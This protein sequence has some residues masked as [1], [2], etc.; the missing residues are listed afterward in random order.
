MGRNFKAFKSHIPGRISVNAVA[1][2]VTNNNDI[3]APTQ[4][5][6]GPDAL[7]SSVKNLSIS[8]FKKMPKK[9]KNPKRLSS[10]APQIKKPNHFPVIR[11]P[12]GTEKA[13]KAMSESN[14]LVFVV[15]KRADKTNIKEAVNM[16]FKVR[17][18]KVNTSIMP[19][20]I[21]KAFIMLAP[22]FK[23]SDVAKKI[24]IF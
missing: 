8:S 4:N 6:S 22:E 11:Y 5:L 13:I 3:D 19:G 10:S 21:K 16:M 18:K 2:E 1:S 20:G 14:T 7:A 12:L 23:A 15:D 24:G 9:E 17:A